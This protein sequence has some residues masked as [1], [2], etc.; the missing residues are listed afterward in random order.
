MV[1]RSRTTGN[2]LAGCSKRL[3]SKAPVSEAARRYTPHFVWAVHP[4]KWILVKGEAPLMLP[5]SENLIRYVELLSEARTPH[6]KRRVSA[7]RG[8]AGE[9]SDFFSLLRASFPLYRWVLA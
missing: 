2:P 9:E 5:T 1:R 4:C 3:S 7:R 8:L 6:G